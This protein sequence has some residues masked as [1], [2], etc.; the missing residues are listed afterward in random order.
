MLSGYELR[1]SGNPATGQSG[2][3]AIRQP[4]NPAIRQSGNRAQKRGAGKPA[5]LNPATA[6]R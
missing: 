2:N 5:P 4:G 3:R 1:Q 6:P